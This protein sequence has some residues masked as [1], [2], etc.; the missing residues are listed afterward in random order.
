MNHHSL[1]NAIR[2]NVIQAMKILPFEH[3]K[4]L[5]FFIQMMKKSYI[6]KDI[7]TRQEK[8][9]CGLVG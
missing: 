5:I 6:Y 4:F 3:M 2:S 9:H 8:S 7:E 1:Q